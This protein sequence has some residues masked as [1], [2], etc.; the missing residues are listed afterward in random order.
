MYQDLIE[1][2]QEEN[3][4]A[5]ILDGLNAA[6]SGIARRCSNKT[7]LVY[8]RSKIIEILSKDMSE[9]EADE[10]TSYNIEGA[11]MGDST[12]YIMENMNDV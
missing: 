2:L 4:E 11:W 5:I 3:P 9:E 7:V 12:P 8:D 1:I 10:F 6:I